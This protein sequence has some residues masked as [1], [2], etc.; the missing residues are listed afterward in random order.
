MLVSYIRLWLAWHETALHAATTIALRCARLG[1][2]LAMRGGLSSGECWRMIT[3]KQVAAIESLA[4]AWMVLPKADGIKIAAA[5]L[6]PYRRRT[7]VNSRRLSR[8]PKRWQGR[9][10][11]AAKT[12]R[13]RT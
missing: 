1:S 4:G 7:R 2:D 12:A 5:A 11:N 13:N 6:R 8:I 10:G 9:L 3:E